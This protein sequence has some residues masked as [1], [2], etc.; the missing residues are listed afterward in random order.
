MTDTKSHDWMDPDN[1]QEVEI[2]HLVENTDLSPNQAG[3]LVREHG[4]DRDT[5]MKIAA[6]IK[7]ES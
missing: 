7:A 4:T 5:L 2:R 3:A 6:T 1:A